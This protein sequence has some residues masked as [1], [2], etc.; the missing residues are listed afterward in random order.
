MNVSPLSLSL[1]HQPR[2]FRL[3][4][5][6]IRPDESSEPSALWNAV[7]SEMVILWLS[8]L[9]FEFDVL[10]SLSLSSLIISV[11]TFPSCYHHDPPNWSFP[12][13][14]A[15]NVLDPNSVRFHASVTVFQ[16]ISI[17]YIVFYCFANFIM[18]VDSIASRRSRLFFRSGELHPMDFVQ[19]VRVYLHCHSSSINRG[20]I[21][22]SPA[23]ISIFTAYLALL[24]LLGRFD[25][26]GI[27]VIM[28][29]EIMK[30]LLHVLS[31]FS[32]LIFGF[33]LTFCV[34]RPV[35]RVSFFFFFVVVARRAVFASFI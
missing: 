28:F 21:S 3:D 34:I 5:G 10:S 12:A 29:L 14:P 20:I 15:C 31:L 35:P 26:Y 27:Y 33:A 22:G 8:H 17:W 9:R 23:S 13:T 24:F 4:D 16:L 11:I 7:A 19:S 18:E 6:Q 2:T 25:I 32:I 30:T 1:H